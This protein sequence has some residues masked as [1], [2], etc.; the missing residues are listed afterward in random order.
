LIQDADEYHAAAMDTDD[1]SDIDKFNYITLTWDGFVLFSDF[2]PVYGDVW[3]V[4]PYSDY[5]N[6]MKRN[7]VVL[8][9]M[10]K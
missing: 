6:S 3:A 4:L 2:D 10:N 9:L 7:S 8:D 5:I 1:T